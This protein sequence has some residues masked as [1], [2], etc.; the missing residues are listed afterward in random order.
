MAA[1]KW[2][3][4]TNV[5][6]ANG[7]GK[8]IAD[9]TFNAQGGHVFK[10]CD[11]DLAGTTE[12]FTKPFDFPIMGDFSIVVNTGGVDVTDAY[13]G[14]N[15]KINVYGS[16]DGVNWTDALDSVA[17]KDFDTKPYVHVYDYDEEGRMPFMRIG[18]DGDGAGT[19]KI[20][21]AVIPH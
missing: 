15:C 3:K 9:G 8:R 2:Y 18:L 14:T 1:S 17:N 21:V 19:E 5:V 13:F 12:V 16:V 7:A 11:I 10:E 20:K 6:D 4:I